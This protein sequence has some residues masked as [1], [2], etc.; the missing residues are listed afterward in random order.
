MR[1]PL[2]RAPGPRY[3]E[4]RAVPSLHRQ[5]PAWLTTGGGPLTPFT[6]SVH[7]TTA[8]PLEVRLRVPLTVIAPSIADGPRRWATWPVDR[9]MLKASAWVAG[10]MWGIGD[11]QVGQASHWLAKLQARVHPGR[12]AVGLVVGTHVTYMRQLL[13]DVDRLSPPAGT[14][15]VVNGLVN[16]LITRVLGATS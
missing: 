4:G 9:D 6:L 12:V 11:V 7:F 2:F 5:F 16:D 8:R 13:G 3:T 1:V 10:S 14:A 15:D